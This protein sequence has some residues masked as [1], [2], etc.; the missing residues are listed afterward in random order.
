MRKEGNNMEKLDEEVRKRHMG[1]LIENELIPRIK[2]YDD[3]RS[4][5]VCVFEFADSYE[6]DVEEVLE[7]LK[8]REVEVELDY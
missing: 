2:T 7:M 5:I 3:N 4:K 6:Y 8:E 1:V